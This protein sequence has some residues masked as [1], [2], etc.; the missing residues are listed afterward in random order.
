MARAGTMPFHRGLF[1]DHQDI[2]LQSKNGRIRVAVLILA[3]CD[4]WVHGMGG[5]WQV[6]KG[7]ARGG[8]R[9]DDEL[10]IEGSGHERLAA[11]VRVLEGEYRLGYLSST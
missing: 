5:L 8:E 9:L 7:H 4:E 3:W 11:V 10:G 1:G 2:G 6:A